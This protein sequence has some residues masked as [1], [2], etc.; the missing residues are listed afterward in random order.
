MV[1]L[2]ISM[3]Q[4]LSSIHDHQLIPAK[5]GNSHRHNVM[6]IARQVPPHH[7]QSHPSFLQKT[8]LL[9][10]FPF[11]H[12]HTTAS[13]STSVP[14]SFNFFQVSSWRAALTSCFRKTPSISSTLLPPPATFS[15]LINF[16]YDLAY[17]W[18]PPIGKRTLNS[19]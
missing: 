10:F 5:H 8:F 17:T 18:S 19:L 7:L 11:H 1:A 16:S 3:I 15:R 14:V 6:R 4:I 12:R 13:L 9:R 2:N